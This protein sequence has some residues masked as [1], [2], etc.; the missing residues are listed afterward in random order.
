MRTKEYAWALGA[1]TLCT[2]LGW[3]LRPFLDRSD[4]AML[5]LLGVLIV[6]SRASRGP[7]LLASLA[8]VAAFDFFFVPP[9][10]TFAVA[11]SKYWVTFAVMLAAGAMVSSLTLR[12]R[13]QAAAVEAERLRN[14]LLSSVSHDLRTP[15]AAVTGAATSLLDG[16]GRLDAD[17]QHELLET[18][19]DESERL[20]RMVGDILDV[21]RLESGSL[22]LKKEWVPLEEIV[23]SALARLETRLK[24]RELKT[25]LPAEVLLA[26]LDPTLAEQ[27]L[28]NLLENAAK[29]TPQGSPIQITV[30][31]E[32][33]ETVVEVADR[34]PGIPRGEE[35]RIFE[36]FHR[37][38]GK[39]SGIGLGLTVCRAIAKAHGGRIQ[40]ENREGGGA[41]FRFSLPLEGRPPEVKDA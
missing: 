3:L 25:S 1:V 32:G 8:G 19:R 12:I 36:R 23:G 22:A 24:G 27:L 5:Y 21:T 29:Y 26:P 34:G 6:A 41:V 18:I 31:R 15:L 2:G 14:T 10:F 38:A 30:R 33:Q 37:A 20:N 28:V 35:E 40:A 39:G 7:A 17:A 4:Q 9:Y 13:R 11:E 16:E